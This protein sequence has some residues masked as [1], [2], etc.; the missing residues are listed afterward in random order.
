MNKITAAAALALSLTLAAGAASAGD[1]EEGAKVFKK[2]AICHTLDGKNKVG[3][4]LQGMFGR[5]AGGVE[6]YKYSSALKDSGIVWDET[7]V[8]AYLKDPK[9]YIP[10]NKMAFPGLKKDKELD[11]VIAYLKSATN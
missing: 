9:G 1:V 4:T 2:C 5:A 11:D 6:G 10:K 3:P 7:T 8:A